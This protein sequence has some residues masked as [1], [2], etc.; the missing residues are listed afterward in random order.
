LPT[1]LEPSRAKM[2]PRA[3]TDPLV[4]TA[5]STCIRRTSRM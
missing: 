5:R 4:T 2:L 3:V 1:P